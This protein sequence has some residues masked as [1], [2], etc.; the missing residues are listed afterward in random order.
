MKQKR[1]TNLNYKKKRKKPESNNVEENEYE[2]INVSSI[3]DEISLKQIIP[4]NLI[5]KDINNNI[6]L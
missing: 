2:N 1:I 5:K 6:Y 3:A 4:N